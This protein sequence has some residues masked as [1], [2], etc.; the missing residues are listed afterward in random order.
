MQEMLNLIIY[1]KT[2]LIDSFCDNSN[3]C[4][5]GNY[6]LT[7]INETTKEVC[8]NIQIGNKNS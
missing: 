4:N 5:H 8:I 7:A 2:N 1:I 6:L 3:Y